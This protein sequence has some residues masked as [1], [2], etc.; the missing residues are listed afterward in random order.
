MLLINFKLSDYMHENSSHQAMH[1]GQSSMP[2]VDERK[3]NV[4]HFVLQY[5]VYEGG[6]TFCNVVGCPSCSVRERPA[7]NIWT[8]IWHAG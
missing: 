1:L 6:I 4:S 8:V 5:D 7:K 3:E 2:K